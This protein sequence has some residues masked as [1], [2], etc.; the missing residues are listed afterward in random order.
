MYLHTKLETKLVSHLR[1][2]LSAWHGE[3]IWYMYNFMKF[4]SF[5]LLDTLYAVLHIPLVDKS[6]QFHLFRIY[7]IPLVHTTCQKSFQYTVKEEYL[8]IRSD[9]Q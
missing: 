9:R 7:N 4:Q 6:L 2:T 1:L 5:M 3:N 8:G